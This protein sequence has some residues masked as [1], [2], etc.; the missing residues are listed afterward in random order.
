MR[1]L[2]VATNETVDANCLGLSAETGVPQSRTSPPSAVRSPAM[3]R[4]NELFP[5][6]LR[7]MK[8]VSDAR[9]ISAETSSS[10][11]RGP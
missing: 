7:P 2:S 11:T 1:T 4:S 9:G 10:S 3:T 8:A 6:P 5:V